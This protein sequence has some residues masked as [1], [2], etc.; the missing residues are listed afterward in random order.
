MKK[1]SIL[2][3]LVGIAMLTQAQTS[4][5]DTVRTDRWSTHLHLGFSN[6]TGMR[7][8]QYVGSHKTAP[9]FSLGVAYNL[10]AVWRFDF[11]IGYSNFRYSA[12]DQLA[13]PPQSSALGLLPYTDRN[14][15]H[16]LFSDLSFS[17]NLM[18]INHTRNLQKLNVW[19]G[20]GLGLMH[21]WNTHEQTWEIETET[22][23]WT[24]V[25][26]RDRQ[27]NTI[28]FPVTLAAEYDVMPELTLGLT[29]Q[30]SAFPLSRNHTPKSMWFMALTVRYNWGIKRADNNSM[31]MQKLLES[32]R[33]Q[34]QYRDLLRQA[35][36]D[37]NALIDQQMALRDSNELLMREN[38][39]LIDLIIDLRDERSRLRQQVSEMTA[40]PTPTPVATV[41]TTANETTLAAATTASVETPATESKKKE[42]PTAR[43]GDTCI[44]FG[45]SSSEISSEG[46]ET[47]RAVGSLLKA[48]PKKKV[49]I[50][51]Y[52]SSTG[53]V[54]YNHRLS[55]DRIYA[56][57]KALL[58]AGA[59]PGQFIGD[60]ANGKDNMGASANNRKV[61]ILIKN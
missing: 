17:Y 12:D 60:R 48:N 44:Y 27:P 42:T 9:L 23:A 24:E 22:D 39:S 2:F 34:A 40:A 10:T 19:L 38:D 29:T 56:V 33:D 49:F 41:E 57:R 1:H 31:V 4:Y 18:E 36:D 61:K 20:V 16:L 8:K 32:Y 15:T 11:N 35:A 53:N 55:E 21:G 46:M 52:A 47:I 58:R 50:I 54:D 51:G 37:N 3:L 30:L 7:G 45:V 25:R 5:N 14:I 13:K 43:L 6:H 59:R 26:T 28:Y